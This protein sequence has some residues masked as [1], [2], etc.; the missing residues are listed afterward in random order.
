M[1]T[2]NNPT[3]LLE[4]CEKATNGPYYSDGMNIYSLGGNVAKAYRG[5]RI[6]KEMNA[7]ARLIARLSPEV[8]RA[9]YEALT[10]IY[11]KCGEDYDERDP[12][13]DIPGIVT[14]IK[15]LLDGHNHPAP[16]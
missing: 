12:F 15:A 2:T 8:V 4:L 16:K 3:P 14:E 7:N 10:T 11:R 6:A 9:V 1:T 13:G 5:N